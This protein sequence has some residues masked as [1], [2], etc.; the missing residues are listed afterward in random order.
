MSECFWDVSEAPELVG[1]QVGEDGVC[2]SVSAGAYMC[3]VLR[4]G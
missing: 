1:F 4:V 3:V 2:T